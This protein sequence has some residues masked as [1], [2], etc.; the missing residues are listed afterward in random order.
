M[1]NKKI[2][3]GIDVDNVVLDF[4][5]RFI[6]CFYEETGLL[7]TR[8]EIT[9]WNFKNYI[10]DK[11]KDNKNICG[12]MVNEMLFSVRLITNMK[13]KAKSR[14]TIFDMAKNNKV[15]IVFITALSENLINIRKDWFANNFKDINYEL[16]FE[17]KKSNIQIDYLLD[18]GIHNL[19]EL[20]KYIPKENCLCIKE[21]YNINSSYL[22]FDNLHDAYE[23]ILNKENLT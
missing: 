17:S 21:P 7:L 9:N 22:N 13:Y 1:K 5:E 3:I 4:T 20:S 10:D 12:E 2:R 15:E 6:E 8:E 11:Y 16:H 14:E 19:D 23:Y 18:D